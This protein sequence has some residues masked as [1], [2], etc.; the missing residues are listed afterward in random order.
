MS[1]VGRK[2]LN[3]FRSFFLG[4]GGGWVLLG[5]GVRDNV[6]IMHVGLFSGG[7]ILRPFSSCF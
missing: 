2:T 7:I 1:V 6:W 4:G 5:C 3:P